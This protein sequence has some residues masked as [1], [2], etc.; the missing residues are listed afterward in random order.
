M[1]LQKLFVANT[2]DQHHRFMFPIPA[3]R[4]FATIRIAAGK[5]VLVGEFD[6]A[7]M[8]YP[9]GRTRKPLEEIINH[10]VRYGM[11]KASDVYDGVK[12]VGLCYEIG[13]P[14]TFERLRGTLE[15]N[16]EA[17]FRQARARRLDTAAAISSMLADTLHQA[18]GK[19]K[20]Q[21]RPAH[22]DIELVEHDEGGDANPQ[23]AVGLEVPAQGRAPRHGG[24]AAQREA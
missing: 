19:P 20:E 16:S 8:L 3:S 9:D 14:V 21:M 22:V 18:T 23:F 2:T 17:R 12:F 1:A 7:G 5:Q 10:H 11:R 13:A 4:D 24:G 15:T 6:D